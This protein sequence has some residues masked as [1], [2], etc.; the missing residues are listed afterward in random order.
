MLKNWKELL[1]GVPVE[2]EDAALEEM[3][4]RIVREGM[5]AAAILF[6]ESSKPLSFLTGQAAIAATPLIGGFIEPM[7]LERYAYLFSNRAFIERL[8]RRIEELEAERAG[9]GRTRGESES[10]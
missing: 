10:K 2:D 7:R 6:L 5:G 9:K 3:A 1:Q 4:Q 8:I